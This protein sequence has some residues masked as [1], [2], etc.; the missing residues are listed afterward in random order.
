M[1]AGRRGSGGRAHPR[2]CRLHP[3]PPS[4]RP[5]TRCA[6]GSAGPSA[7]ASARHATPLPPRAPRSARAPA[8]ALAPPRPRHAQPP[9]H[10]RTSWGRTPPSSPP[11]PAPAAAPSSPA[12]AASAPT[13]SSPAAHAASSAGSPPR[14]SSAAKPGAAS[15]RLSASCSRCAWYATCRAAAIQGLDPLGIKACL[16]YLSV[17]RLSPR[18]RGRR[19]PPAQQTA[20]HT[21]R[22]QPGARRGRQD[23]VG[24]LRCDVAQRRAQRRGR[25]GG[26]PPETGEEQSP[27]VARRVHF[28]Q[29]GH[30]SS[31]PLAVP[32][33][34]CPR[35]RHRSFRFTCCCTR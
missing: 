22:E 11:P 16:R 20:P 8:H 33:T 24:G 6:N 9:R 28:V 21:A 29:S 17:P 2:S 4:T 10:A 14:L 7:A 23:L 31:R 35:S 26:V 3:P 32:D 30:V 1:A 34:P 25:A 27:A 15:S 18:P 13:A 19:H 5:Q 12:A